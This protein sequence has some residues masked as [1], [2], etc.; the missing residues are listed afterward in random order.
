MTK[1]AAGAS[2]VDCHV[3]PHRTPTRAALEREAL[4]LAR[5]FDART[6]DSHDIISAATVLPQMAD[7]LEQYFLTPEWAHEASQG[8]YMQAAWLEERANNEPDRSKRSAL[9]RRASAA[10]AAAGKLRNLT[11]SRCQACGGATPAS[12]KPDATG[13][14]VCHETPNVK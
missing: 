1:T 6:E 8:A 12:G 7:M 13:E 11:V 9:L 2:P 10:L 4:R 14:C 3:R 5:T